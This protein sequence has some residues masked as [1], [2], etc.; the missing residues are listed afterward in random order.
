[1]SNQNSPKSPW[2]LRRI[3]AIAAIVL[4]V[5]M[6]LVTFVAAILSHPGAADLF[7]AS[8][9]MTIAVPIMLWIILYAVKHIHKD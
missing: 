3:A 9:T 2:T 7:R 8:L 1:M 5:G 4:L 6:Y